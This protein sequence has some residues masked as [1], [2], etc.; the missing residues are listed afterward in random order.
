VIFQV[1]IRRPDPA[2]GPRRGLLVGVIH[3][4]PWIA[5]A[6]AGVR[7]G[8]VGELGDRGLWTVSSVVHTLTLLRG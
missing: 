7:T 4:G 6:V 5:C 8:A 3:R 2:P 1:A